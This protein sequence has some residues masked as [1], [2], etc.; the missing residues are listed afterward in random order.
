MNK[1]FLSVSALIAAL[2]AFFFSQLEAKPHFIEVS[3]FSKDTVDI[4]VR[5]SGEKSP[6]SPHAVLGP[7]IKTDI[8]QNIPGTYM[9]VVAVSHGYTPDWNPTTGTCKHLLTTTDH[10]VVI[11]D[12]ALGLKFTCEIAKFPLRVNMDIAESKNEILITADLPG[13]EEKDIN[14]ELDS[15]ILTIGGEKRI[16]YEEK[17]KN[18]YL[19]ERSS[20]LF[21][22]SLS[23]PTHVNED[24]I[25]AKFKNGVLTVTLPKSQEEKEKTKRVEVRSE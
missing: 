7:N 9:D 2:A 18:F 1:T 16:D 21:T 10:T 4:Y 25:E 3:N 19:I 24:S 11:D 20:G 6:I 5:P 17:G 23:I 12:A 15:G 8:K 14:I 13:L 22:R